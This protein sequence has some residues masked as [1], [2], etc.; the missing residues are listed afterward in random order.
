VAAL[1]PLLPAGGRDRAGPADLVDAWQTRIHALGAAGALYATLVPLVLPAALVV[2]W[3]HDRAPPSGRGAWR[4]D[5]GALAFAALLGACCVVG[6]PGCHEGPGRARPARLFLSAVSTCSDHRPAS[7]DVGR[8]RTKPVPLAG[9]LGPRLSGTSARPSR[10]DAALALACALL[11]AAFVWCAAR[12]RGAG[13]DLRRARALGLVCRLTRRRVL[14]TGR[15]ALGVA[16]WRRCCSVS[17]CCA[18]R[19]LTGRRGAPAP[20]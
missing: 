10:R 15:R 11:S 17:R 7:Y 20:V 16:G 1:A 18:P 14:G 12:G 6:A 8:Y 9:R 2:A 3:A 5:M 13:V 4:Y 19:N